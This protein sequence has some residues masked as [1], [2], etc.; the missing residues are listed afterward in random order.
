M[1][2]GIEFTSW[3]ERRQAET[4][5]QG[6]VD[7]LDWAAWFSHIQGLIEAD[8]L[9]LI[10]EPFEGMKRKTLMNREYFL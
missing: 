8:V 10:F 5:L 4:Q 3:S 7:E 1:L 6:G 2:L 9:S